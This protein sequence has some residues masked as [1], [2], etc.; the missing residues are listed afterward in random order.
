VVGSLWLVE[1]KP[2]PT[3]KSLLV[4]AVDVVAWRGVNE[5]SRDQIARRIA[6][7]ISWITLEVLSVVSCILSVYL[8]AGIA[9]VVG[10]HAQLQRI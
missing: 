7:R 10:Y 9:Q 8:T 3:E 1:L 5:L 4:A 6:G 2:V